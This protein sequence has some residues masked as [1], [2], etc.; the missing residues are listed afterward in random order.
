MT[1]RAVMMLTILVAL[2]LSVGW[3]AHAAFSH[4]KELNRLAAI[5]DE[6]KCDN[7]VR[8]TERIKKFDLPV[9]K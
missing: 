9:K 1:R 3:Y 6:I 5:C 2:C 7:I 4:L 8:E